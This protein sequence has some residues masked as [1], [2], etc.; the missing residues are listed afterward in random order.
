MPHRWCLILFLILI[1]PSPSF[2]QADTLWIGGVPLELGMSK[3]DAMQ[4][5]NKLG[6]L[7]KLQE[8]SDETLSISEG[9]LPTGGPPFR[10]AGTL[11][12]RNGKLVAINK[13]W[14]GFGGDQAKALG[15]AIYSVLDTAIKEGK[16]IAVIQAET[17]HLPGE[18]SLHITFHLTS[19]K[20]I[21][22]AVPTAADKPNLT[23]EVSVQ[24]VVYTK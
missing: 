3:S 17:F 11:V 19:G 23:Y 9:S 5:L 13:N 16:S 8:V 4:S 2:G 12:F 21:F 22:I 10:M 7:Y 14:G 6:R 20:K 15:K 24:E 18:I 1:G